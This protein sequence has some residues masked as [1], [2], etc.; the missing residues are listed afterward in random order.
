MK[1]KHYLL[2]VRQIPVRLILEETSFYIL[3]CFVGDSLQSEVTWHSFYTYIMKT[4][5]LAYAETKY[6]GE[7]HLAGSLD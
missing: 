3:L 1:K 6:M 7:M 2:G 4:L 5:F